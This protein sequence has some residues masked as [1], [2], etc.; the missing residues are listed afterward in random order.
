MSLRQ[1]E[2]A[3]SSST[4]AIRP[5][6]S[7]ELVAAQEV[8]SLDLC[9]CDVALRLAQVKGEAGDSLTGGNSANTR[10]RTWSQTQSHI[11]RAAPVRS[12]MRSEIN[13]RER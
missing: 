12:G 4:Y 5:G 13:R 6:C 9:P 7:G 3:A 2:R 11:A 8:A 10:R 1:H